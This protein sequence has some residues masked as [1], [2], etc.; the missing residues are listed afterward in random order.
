MTGDAEIFRKVVEYFARTAV[1]KDPGAPITLDTEVYRDL[2]VY[3]LDLLELELWAQREFG[4][5]PDLAISDY[6]PPENG[7]WLYDFVR[8]IIGHEKH[9]KS[10]KIRDV[11]EAIEAKK[12][13]AK[14]DG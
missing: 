2:R 6:V 14:G 5:E 1:P 12:W 7:L 3:G 4:V 13:F 9:Y 10:L 8:R 11:I